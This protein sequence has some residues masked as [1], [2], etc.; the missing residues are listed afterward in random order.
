MYPPPHIT[1]MRQM[2]E[3]QKAWS[4]GRWNRSQLGVACHTIHPLTRLCLRLYLRDCTTRTHTLSLSRVLSLSRRSENCFETVT[5]SHTHTHTHTC[6]VGENS[7]LGEK[8]RYFCV[9]AL[10]SCLLL[11][12]ICYWRDDCFGSCL[13]LTCLFFF[14]LLLGEDVVNTACDALSQIAPWPQVCVYVYR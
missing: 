12:C 9:T 10:N 14:F 2:S 13:L 7:A 4:K 5:F 6:S 11:T 3:S 8:N 1:C